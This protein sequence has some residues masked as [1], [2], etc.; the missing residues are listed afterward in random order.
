LQAEFGFAVEDIRSI[1]IDAFTWALRLNN[2]AAPKTEESAQ[3][4]IPFCTALALTRGADALIEIGAEALADPTTTTLAAKVTLAVDP[5][6]DAMFPAEVPSR[7]RICTKNGELMKE[8]V[9]PLGEP[10]NPM[11][12]IRLLQ[13]FSQV[14]QGRLAAP[15]L[16]EFL[17]AFDA[18]RDG[19]PRPL[20]EALQRPL[21]GA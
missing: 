1:E 20:I 13:K 15:H 6:Y 2:E 19:G 14:A 16:R 3:Y 5:V 7:V 4:S 18:L 10:T 21:L 17:A 8:V 11:D 12:W 9:A